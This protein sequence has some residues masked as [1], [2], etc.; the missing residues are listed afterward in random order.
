MCVCKARS[1]LNCSSSEAALLLVKFLRDVTH[2]GYFS[3]CE[4]SGY[5]FPWQIL[6]STG[7]LSEG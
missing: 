5:E 3:L 2:F 4:A 7:R 6:D 1:V